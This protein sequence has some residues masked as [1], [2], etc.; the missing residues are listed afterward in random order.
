MIFAYAAGMAIARRQRELYDFI[1]RYSLSAGSP[2]LESFFPLYPALKN[3]LRNSAVP[4]GLGSF[5]P[6]LP[7]PR[8]WAI[9][10][11]PSG[12]GILKMLSHWPERRVSFVTASEALG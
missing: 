9:V 3:P 5:S 8:R 12:A 6:L 1:S 7:A 10:F 4:P 2:G 11:R